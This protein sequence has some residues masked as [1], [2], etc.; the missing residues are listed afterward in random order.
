MV[1][2]SISVFLMGLQRSLL[3]KTT[4]YIR[5]HDDELTHFSATSNQLK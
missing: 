3:L 5:D 1:V 2:H 4:M